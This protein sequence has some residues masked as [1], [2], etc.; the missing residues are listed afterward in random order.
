MDGAS[1][2]P[3][4]YG[5]HQA[6]IGQ[7]RLLEGYAIGLAIATGTITL[8]KCREWLN[9]AGASQPHELA[10]FGMNVRDLWSVGDE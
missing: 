7:A 3:K 5:V 6:D 4:L 8:G 2:E 10:M 9:A 1:I